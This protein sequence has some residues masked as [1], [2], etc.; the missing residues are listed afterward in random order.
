MVGHEIIKRWY[1]DRLKSWRAQV[2]HTTFLF[3][4]VLLKSG[5]TL[6]YLLQVANHHEDLFNYIM[7]LRI[8][9]FL[10]NWFIN[11]ASPII[12]V[13]VWPFFA[14][15]FVGESPAVQLPMLSMRFVFV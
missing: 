8:T 3:V 7:F 1:P 10:P 14:G 2:I 13:P 4:I 9:P 12:G 15:T 5:H 11:I 6:L